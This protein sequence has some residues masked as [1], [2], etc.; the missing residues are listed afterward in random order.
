MKK[1]EM[2]IS[3]LVKNNGVVELS[4]SE[5]KEILDGEADDFL[6]ALLDGEAMLYR[7][8]SKQAYFKFWKEAGYIVEGGFDKLGVKFTPH[9]YDIKNDEP[10]TGKVSR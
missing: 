10:V 7:N 4:Y 5:I 1:F 2:L 8:R 3:Y 9:V 6:S